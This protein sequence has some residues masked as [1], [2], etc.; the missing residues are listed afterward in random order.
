MNFYSLGADVG[1][2][3]KTQTDE[4]ILDIIE[5]ETNSKGINI[6]MD[7]VMA[8]NYNL[9]IETVAMLIFLSFS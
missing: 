5:K 3:Y 2:N 8:K 1:F 4:T 7:C 9:V 6:L